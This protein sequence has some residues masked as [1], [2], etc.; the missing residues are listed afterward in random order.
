MV[1]L[2]GFSKASPAERIEKLAQAGLLSE[3]GLQTVRDNDTLPLS[4][5]NE[6]VENVLGTLALPFGIAPGFQIDDQEIQ[7]PMVTEEP[8]VIAAASYAAGLIKR[9]GGFQ[10]QVHKRQ[11]I[12][13]VALYDVS[14]KEKASQAITEAKEELLQLANQAY[15]SIVKRGGGARDLWTEV[16]GD[17][18][19]CYLSVDP[20]EA[21]G[22][23][24]LNTMLEAL[25]DPLEELSGGQGLMAI[26]S[27]LATDAL[28]TARC[29]IDYR[30]LSRDP[31]EAA[32]IAQKI[33]LAS[34]LAAVDPYR[35]AT[36]NKGIFNGIDA[37]VLATGNDWR[38][39]EAGGHTYA[40]RSG[41]A[42]GLSNWMDH[43]EQQVLEGQ[44]TLPMP[45]ATKGGSIGLNPSVQ[46]A[47]ELLGNPD[48]QTLARIIVS[49]GLA[50]N[51]AA[52]KALVS[53]GIQHGHM[54]LQA[55]SLALLA[56]ATP[57]EVAPVVQALLEDKPFNLEKAQA[58]LEE[59]RQSK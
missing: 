47:H 56:G 10:T 36:H 31:K 18:L 15:P 44:L 24:M 58:V 11:M 21:M 14:N 9:S 54:K 30:F 8:S 3:E 59:I 40:S 46:V 32:E 12:G 33:A 19:I 20:K 27:N 42:L 7:V 38:A 16:K 4:L 6:M 41:Q 2:T 5:A 43:P 51:F 45:I 52:L 55:K 1:K 39:I 35:A 22:A 23:N 53:T 26:L 29:H 49:V 17:F 50:Q 57:S 28:V 48:A 34:Q 25:V 13:Q 37:V